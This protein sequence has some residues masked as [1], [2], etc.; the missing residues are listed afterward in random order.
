MNSKTACKKLITIAKVLL[1]KGPTALKMFFSTLLLGTF[2]LP[3]SAYGAEVFVTSPWLALLVNFI[4]GVNVRA[5]PIQDWNEEGDLTRR[6]RPRALQSLP[7]ESFIMAFDEKDAQSVGIPLERY[8]N[9]RPL[10]SHLPLDEE[11]ID[12]SFSD[13]SVIPFIAQRVLTA[14]AGWDPVNYPYYQRRLA[15]FQARLYS[16]TLAGRQV[17]KGQL[18]YDLTGHSGLLLQAAGC[19]LTR[20][21]PEELSAWA[22][23]KESER[24]GAAIAQMAGEEAAIV[25]DYSTPKAIRALVAS[26]PATFLIARPKSEQDYPAFLHDQYL[27]LWSKITSKPLKSRKSRGLSG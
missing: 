20:P 10:Y 1:I 2:L 21:A 16:T 17:L 14:L 26:N 4:G 25:M 19:K 6:V 23:G 13:P 7:P 9:F 11:K 18:V 27:S 15:E 22:S 5:I 8:G 12:V 24:L 3:C